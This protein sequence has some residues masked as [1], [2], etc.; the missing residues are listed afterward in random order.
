[1]QYLSGVRSC[2]KPMV[3]WSKSG[4]SAHAWC[5]S[6]PIQSHPRFMECSPQAGKSQETWS[7]ALHM[8]NYCPTSRD[9]TPLKCLMFPSPSQRHLCK[10]S[11]SSEGG[12]ASPSEIKCCKKDLKKHTYKTSI[13]IYSSVLHVSM[14]RPCFMPQLH[15][16][17]SGHKSNVIF[18]Q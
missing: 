16:S 11:T 7:N 2:A 3:L 14:P 10:W 18:P 9:C 5:T 12:A 6:S 13:T 17:K 4:L 8:A 15:S 1:M